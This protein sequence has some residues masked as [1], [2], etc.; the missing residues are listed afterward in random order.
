[1]V[2]LTM[3]P[4]KSFNSVLHCDL[5]IVTLMSVIMQMKI[6]VMLSILLVL[7]LNANVIYI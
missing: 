7:F 3:I 6:N 1:M 5:T 4:L 2:L